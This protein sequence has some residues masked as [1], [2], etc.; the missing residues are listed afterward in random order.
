MIINLLSLLCYDIVIAVFWANRVYTFFKSL[1]SQRVSQGILYVLIFVFTSSWN[2][3]Y[4][5]LS[6]MR[7]ETIL[8]MIWPNSVRLIKLLF[9]YSFLILVSPVI[10]SILEFLNNDIIW[11]TLTWATVATN[12]IVLLILDGLLVYTFAKHVSEIRRDVDVPNKHLDIISRWGGAAGA[13]VVL[14]SISSITTMYGLMAGEGSYMM[15]S[16]VIMAGLMHVVSALLLGMKYRLYR[17]SLLET[18]R[19]VS[20]NQT[21]VRK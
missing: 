13:V 20:S 21:A 10:F 14:I 3:S 9:K 19:T 7:S 5:H 16:V 17:E 11:N 4:L 1:P 15:T 2:I 12:D 8:K 6:Y 18:A